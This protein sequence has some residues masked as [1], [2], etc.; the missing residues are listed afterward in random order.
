MDALGWVANFILVAGALL[1]GERNP[2]AFVLIA[3]G[4]A[5][6]GVKAYRMR[7]WDMFFICVVFGLLAVRNLILWS[8]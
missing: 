2:I 3:A 5:L 6:W 1:V 7:Q 8:M 4:E